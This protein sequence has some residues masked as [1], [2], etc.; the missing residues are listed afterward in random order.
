MP[1]DL[2]QHYRDL[3]RAYGNDHR[4]VQHADAGSQ[5][6]RFEMLTAMLPPGRVAVLDVGCG[7]GHLHDYLAERRDDFAYLGVDVVPEFVEE[8]R[9]THRGDPRASFELLD[10]RRDP[11]PSGFDV[12]IVCG[13]F[14]NRMPDNRAFM[15]DVLLR[16]FGAVSKGIAFNALSTYVDYQDPDLHY[17]DPRDVL[18]FCKR[19]LSRKVAMR[20][21]YVVREGTIP[22]EYTMYVHK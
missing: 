22:Y 16:L 8:A 18:D 1:S 5:R 9:R 3:F 21:D 7:L 11:L 10:A 4:A 17:A 19:R 13:V 12:G 2:S 14:N 20:H 6:K 15:E